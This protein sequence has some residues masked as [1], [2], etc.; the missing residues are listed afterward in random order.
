VRR[1]H[2]INDVER[3]RWLT[4]ARD[5]CL[6]VRLLEERIPLREEVRGASE[7]L[8]L[9]PLHIA[10]E[11]QFIAVVAADRA[12]EVLEVLRAAPGGEEAVIIGEIRDKPAGSVLCVSS[13]GGTRIVDMLVGDPL[14][15]IC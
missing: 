7:I 11:G 14:P 5:T 13:Y 15:R 3:R 12:D 8:G 2:R 4:L 9:D 1:R 6:G 10:N